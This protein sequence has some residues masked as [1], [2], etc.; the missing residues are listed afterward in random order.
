MKVLAKIYVC[1]ILGLSSGVTWA[2][3][4]TLSRDEQKQTDLLFAFLHHVKEMDSSNVNGRE[5]LDKYLSDKYREPARQ[6]NLRSMLKTLQAQLQDMD[7]HAYT[8]VPWFKYPFPDKLPQLVDETEPITHVMGEPIPV[9]AKPSALEK[10]RLRQAVVVGFEGTPRA[11][12]LFILFTPEK[13]KIFSV[14]F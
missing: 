7:L 6:Q 3:S 4:A 9:P 10:E 13:Y 11:T 8:A 2:Q 1:L 12:G 5:L 14:F